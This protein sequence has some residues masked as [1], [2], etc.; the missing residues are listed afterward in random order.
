MPTLRQD[1]R[2]RL[3]TRPLGY[4]SH[5]EESRPSGNPPKTTPK[6]KLAPLAAIAVI[7]GV[8]YIFMKGKK[9]GED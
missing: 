5:A 2:Q 9:D 4:P 7:A 6:I 3:D 1:R 8:T